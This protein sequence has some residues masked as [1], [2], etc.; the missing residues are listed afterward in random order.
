MKADLRIFASCSDPSVD[1]D[2]TDAVEGERVGLEGDEN[3]DEGF[4]FN[5]FDP[6]GIRMTFWWK[7]PW[8][9]SVS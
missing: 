7:A 2:E 6:A 3:F 5:D 8:M 4:D 1:E 9:V